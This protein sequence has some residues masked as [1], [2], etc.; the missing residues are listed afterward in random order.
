MTLLP[1][2]AML[3]MLLTH[4]LLAYSDAAPVRELMLQMY[5]KPS[6]TQPKLAK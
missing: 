5:K 3:F 1:I 2:Q 6:L 4:L